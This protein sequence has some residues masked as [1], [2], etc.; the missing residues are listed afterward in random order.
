MELVTRRAVILATVFAA[1]VGC[2]PFPEYLYYAGGHIDLS[3]KLL[4]N[5]LER[6]VFVVQDPSGSSFIV[7]G[8]VA[9]ESARALIFDSSFNLLATKDGNAN[10]I[11]AVRDRPL[12]R[13]LGG[14][15]T[16]EFVFDSSNNTVTDESED[17]QDTRRWSTA[18]DDLAV[19][20]TLQG[21]YFFS[22]TT[23]TTPGAQNNDTIQAQAYSDALAIDTGLAFNVTAF[24]DGSSVSDLSVNDV[25]IGNV[26]YVALHM[27]RR[28]GDDSQV[29]SVLIRA[30]DIAAPTAP[31]LPA[32][33]VDVNNPSAGSLPVV[34][35]DA[36]FANRHTWTADGLIYPTYDD[37]LI[38]VDTTTGAIA[39]L[40]AGE[41]A[42]ND[43]AVAADPS[44][45]YV[46][47]FDPT[48][49]ALFR[50]DPWW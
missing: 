22:T 30:A 34:V 24:S 37:E 15:R 32:S 29:Y 3:D 2:S 41:N 46:A 21:Y 25:V 23:S 7:L 27:L 8:D 16:E 33:L 39:T 26:L 20:D 19:A 40:Q 12:P 9:E 49:Q 36:E 17:T 45:R 50:L 43:V 1:V 35:T 48:S 18:Y 47:A 44:G 38:R 42:D 14:L 4:S 13:P 31:I 10:L 6:T 11:N 5:S 28:S